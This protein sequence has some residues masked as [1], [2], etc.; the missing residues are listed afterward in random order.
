MGPQISVVVVECI[1]EL[2]SA[3]WSGWDARR[4]ARDSS[5]E[6]T[7]DGS[8]T[9]ECDI[10]ADVGTDTDGDEDLALEF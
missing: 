1:A 4:A 10:G 9:P 6:A 2:T 5:L 8:E 3:S 7:K